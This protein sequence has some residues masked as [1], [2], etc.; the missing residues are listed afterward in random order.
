MVLIHGENGQGKSNLLEALYLLAI[1]KSS[2]ASSD[3][4]LV[5]RQTTGDA[6]AQ[7]SAIAQREGGPVR[8]Q[9]DLVCLPAEHGR[10]GSVENADLPSVQ[11][12]VRVNGVPRRASRLVGEI[13]SV[14]FSAQDLE[15]VSRP[16]SAR[17]RYLD[18]LISQVD[19]QYLRALQRY[20]RVVGQRNHLLKTIREGRAQAR[21][22]EFWNDELVAS[23]GHIV[24]KRAE[25]VR[26]LSEMAGPIHRGLTGNGE[27]LELVFRPSVPA[28]SGQSEGDIGESLRKA[29]EAERSRE[30]AQGFTVRGPHRDDL[31]MLLDDMDVGLY[32]SRGQCRTVVLAMRLAEASYLRD[33]RGQGPV[34][35]LDDVLSELDASRRAH[36]LD[37]VSQYE[38][39]LITTADTEMIDAEH[40]S[41]MA[42]FVVAG[43]QVTSL[44]TQEIIT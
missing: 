28:D 32:A 43:G 5:R 20:Q 26:V 27:G 18:I 24:A 9:V 41:R 44:A 21:E 42:R 12:Y 13:N 7:V 31:Q 30:V 36:I 38:Q 39:C 3:R 34:L 4:E 8:I 2:R 37:A 15:L 29:M 10:D 16:P 23:G 35:L 6:Q 22:L 14:M 40:L 17:R 11:K 33:K 25:T 1:T 19:S